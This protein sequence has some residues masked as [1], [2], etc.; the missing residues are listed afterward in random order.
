MRKLKFLSLIIT[1][2]ILLSFSLS[3]ENTKN[4]KSGLPADQFYQKNELLT[5]K[6]TATLSQ[7]SNQNR[8][9]NQFIF[10]T[11][12]NKFTYDELHKMG[13][14]KSDIA[15]MEEYRDYPIS[16]IPSS[17]L[18]R[19]GANCTISLRKLSHN[20]SDYETSAGMKAVWRWN[21][22]PLFLGTDIIAF[23]WGEPFSVDVNDSYAEVE[24][25]NENGIVLSSKTLSIYDL[26]PNHGCSFRYKIGSHLGISRGEAYVHISKSRAKIYDFEARAG[27]GHQ[28]FLGY[29]SISWRGITINFSPSINEMDKDFVR[30]RK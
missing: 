22:T 9:S 4:L 29:I 18:S 23:S 28:T 14:S 30:F 5:M 12:L 20:I 6:T 11:A 26:D 19:V 8:N 3:N 27:Y 17:I 25:L 10:N 7:Y 16:N 15:A 2:V 13:Y 21:K 24:F 1:L